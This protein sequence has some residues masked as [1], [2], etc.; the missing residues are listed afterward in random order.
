M[1]RRYLSATIVSAALL[2]LA[3]AT[4]SYLIDPFGLY[5]PT[6]M[7]QLS[8]VAQY[9]HMR[10]V[11]PLRVAQ[12]R[13]TAVL[14]GSSRAGR[15]K[16]DH[17]A[18]ADQT[19]YN[20]S[21][22]GITSYEQYELL[23]FAHRQQPLEDA[24]IALTF[25]GHLAANPLLRE[26]FNPELM[27]AIGIMQYW[28]MA[29]SY[30]ATLMSVTAVTSSVQAGKEANPDSPAYLP[31]GSWHVRSTFFAGIPGFKLV[32]QNFLDRHHRPGVKPRT[33]LTHF[34]SLLEFCHRNQVQ[35]RLAI[36]PS[37][38]FHLEAY[39]AAGFMN[40]W[41]DWHR[42]LQTLNEAVA[43]RHHRPAYP[44]WVFGH[45]RGIMDE[46]I[47]PSNQAAESWFG[48][49]VH[50]KPEFGRLM[51][52]DI[53]LSSTGV[54]A[55]YGQRLDRIDVE[56]YLSDTDQLRQRF[57]MQHPD[58]TNLLLTNLGLR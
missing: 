56:K 10:K 26:G 43:T 21:L 25:N 3:I 24:V 22:P 38:V 54:P 17:P 32:I 58:V 47:L 23:K 37:H 5:Q 34:E 19:T 57:V 52:D 30:A 1:L 20:L 14:I 51:L 44:I 53:L 7:D 15:I 2:L 11:K 33:D 55:S 6:S 45:A 13:P 28:E 35:I 39:A 50:F 40:T 46:A 16:V 48:D 42:Q 12:L 18:W 4:T 49:A 8:R 41:R 27:Q 29:K 36:M 31:D 9:E